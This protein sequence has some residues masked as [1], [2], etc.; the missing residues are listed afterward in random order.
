[1][2]DLFETVSSLATHA[3]RDERTQIQLETAANLPLVECD[4]EQIKQVLLNL[5][6]NAVQAMPEGGKVVLSATGERHGIAIRVLDEGG[7]IP[8]EHLEHIF[9]PFFTLKEAGTGLGLS[10]AHGIVTQHGGTLRVESSSSQGAQFLVMLPWR[11]E[12]RP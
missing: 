7:G 3:L 9:D 4:S 8:A 5:V 2:Q 12:A 1:M 11:Q 6:L 10:V